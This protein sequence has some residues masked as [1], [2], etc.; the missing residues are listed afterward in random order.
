[1]LS[2]S[3]QTLA[4]FFDNIDGIVLT[5]GA[6]MG[7][8]SGLPDFRG[9]QGFWKAYPALGQARISFEEMASPQSFE[10]NPK[11]AW[12]FYGHRLKIY[13]ETFPHEGFSLL[14]RIA[15]R[16]PKGIFVFTSNVDGQFTKAGY[17]EDRILE[18]HG[19]IHYLQCFRDCRGLIWPADSL[20]P[21]IDSERV[22]LRSELP[23][24]PACDG[25]ARP[26]ILMFNDGGWNPS[27]TWEQSQ[28]WQAWRKT[29]SRV[30][31]IEVG[32]GTGVPTVRHFG[33]FLGVPLLRINPREPNT[34][35]DYD[36]SLQMGALEGIR[37]IAGSLGI[38]GWGETR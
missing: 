26:N 34:F 3:H 12:G 17:P 25:L 20:L 6:G 22:R 23:R 37:R 11:L 7:I 29:S 28:R 9:P 4:S 5:A 10:A 36:L 27:R 35:R 15:S 30:I 21:E 18:C 31:V 8:D 16:V 33:E 13:R 32:A 24:C 2:P 19:S 1:M 38:S 14:L